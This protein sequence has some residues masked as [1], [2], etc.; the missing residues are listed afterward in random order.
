MKPLLWKS[1]YE[2]QTDNS[3]KRKRE[4]EDNED[5]TA[6]QM[7]GTQTDSIYTKEVTSMSP[8]QSVI[9]H[10][11]MEKKLNQLA[12]ISKEMDRLNVLSQSLDEIGQL[13]VWLF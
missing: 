9:S 7:E 5:D 2:Q 10:F 1:L 13:N 8:R 4:T 11:L 3:R 12:K 6:V